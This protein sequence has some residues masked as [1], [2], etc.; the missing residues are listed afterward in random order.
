ME[1]FKEISCTNAAAAYIESRRRE[2][3]F[4]ENFLQLLFDNNN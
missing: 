3:N 4:L 1:E 2:N